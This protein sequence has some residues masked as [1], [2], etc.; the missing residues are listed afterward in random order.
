MNLPP[1]V[2][3]PFQKPSL[4]EQRKASG[5]R[6]ADYFDTPF[7]FEKTTDFDDRIKIQLGIIHSI[8]THGVFLEEKLHF[9]AANRN[10]QME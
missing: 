1:G 6:N 8:S 2:L 10:S 9:T 4:A 5:R 7:P 3:S